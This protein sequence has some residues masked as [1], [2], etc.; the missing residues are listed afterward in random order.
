V[1]LNAVDGGVPTTD[2]ADFAP[3][4]RTLAAKQYTGW[5]SLEI[6]HQPENPDTVLGATMRF[7]A[8]MEARIRA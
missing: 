3:A 2:N 1:H 5:V 7:L 6:F 8:D 4:F